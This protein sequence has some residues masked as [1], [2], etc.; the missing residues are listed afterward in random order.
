MLVRPSL[1][2]ASVGSGGF[3]SGRAALIDRSRGGHL[4]TGSHRRAR[5]LPESVS[6]WKQ[7]V[8]LGPRGLGPGPGAAGQP[9]WDVTSLSIAF[10]LDP[11][12]LLRSLFMRPSTHFLTTFRFCLVPPV[13]PSPLVCALPH[14]L[15]VPHPSS[16]HSP[17]TGVVAQGFN[18]DV[19]F[20]WF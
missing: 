17:D 4:R 7:L 13:T 3:N 20:G 14:L 18:E 2:P 16:H 11:K 12:T 6:N 1:I 10:S 19:D 9:S 5:A 8:Q 15:W